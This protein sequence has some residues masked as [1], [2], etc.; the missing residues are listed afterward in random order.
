[1]DKIIIQGCEG[2]IEIILIIWNYEG[3]CHPK[4]NI[5]VQMM[6][7]KLWSWVVEIIGLGLMGFL[8]YQNPYVGKDGL[9]I[10]PK[11]YSFFLLGLLYGHFNIFG[12]YSSSIMITGKPGKTNIYAYKKFLMFIFS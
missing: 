4:V 1:M 2:E 5:Y 8:S 7:R 12:E 10:L 6:D 9:V 11:C 3:I